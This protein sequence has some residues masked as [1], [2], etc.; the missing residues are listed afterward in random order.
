MQQI[1]DSVRRR[2]RR[3]VRGL[4][5]RNTDGPEISLVISQGS[6]ES[7]E[8]YCSLNYPYSGWLG[9]RPS[10]SGNPQFITVCI[11]PATTTI[12][13]ASATGYTLWNV[14][15]MKRIE[16]QTVSSA[17]TTSAITTSVTTAVT[18][19]VLAIASIATSIF[20]T[21]ACDMSYL[22]A[23]VALL[24]STAA[25]GPSRCRAEA[26]PTLPGNPLVCFENLSFEAAQP[27]WRTKADLPVSFSVRLCVLRLANGDSIEVSS[28]M[29]RAFSKTGV[30]FGLP[31][32]PD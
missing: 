24:P 12:T 20:G 23:L 13:T 19:L 21:I 2:R 18:A 7:C 31:A 1:P 8:T 15:T 28:K 22:P 27:S 4:K 25:I 17:T 30:D 9:R 6:G 14:S 16:V 3:R 5:V 32:E 10:A 29:V 11:Y 26:R